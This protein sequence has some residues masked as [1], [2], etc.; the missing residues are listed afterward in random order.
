M[1][2]DS[3]GGSGMRIV[4]AIR[5]FGRLILLISRGY[6]IAQPSHLYKEQE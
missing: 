6:P 5:K 3:A 4:T 2:Q 1:R